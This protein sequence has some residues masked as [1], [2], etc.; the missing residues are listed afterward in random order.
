MGSPDKK[1]RIVQKGNTIA[2]GTALIY[3]R[4]YVYICADLR[5][6]AHTSL[7]TNV[8]MHKY[9]NVRFR[10]YLRSASWAPCVPAVPDRSD[11]RSTYSP[12]RFHRAQAFISRWRQEARVSL[13]NTESSRDSILFCRYSCAASHVFLDL[14][15]HVECRAIPLSRKKVEMRDDSY[16]S[17]VTECR[18]FWFCRIVGRVCL[19]A[20]DPCIRYRLELR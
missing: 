16:E 5:K 9:V 3:V 10:P 12:L 8:L 11:F 2:V 13:E 4:G 14:S 1:L 17:S 19:T 18:L 15:R 6:G 20:R 7:M